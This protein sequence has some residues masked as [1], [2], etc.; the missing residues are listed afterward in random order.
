MKKFLIISFFVLSLV[1]S[2][3][4]MRTVAS[5]R[6]KD[7][8]VNYRKL[9]RTLTDTEVE[10]Y[11]KRKMFERPLEIKD[12]YNNVRYDEV[13]ETR[14][15]TLFGWETKVDTIKTYVSLED[16]GCK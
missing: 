3:F 9:S 8:E 10:D 14:V 15:K 6:M 4:G 13:R 1:V 16:C 11:N 7:S 2:V 12:G 5:F